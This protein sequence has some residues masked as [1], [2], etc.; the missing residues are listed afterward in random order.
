MHALELVQKLS[1]R[2]AKIQKVAKAFNKKQQ[3]K[4]KKRC[5]KNVRHPIHYKVGD[6]VL[7]RIKCHLVGQSKA[8][9]SFWD[10]PHRI[11]YAPID[12]PNVIIRFFD[13]PN[14]KH[15]KVNVERLKKYVAPVLIN[16]Y[17]F[18]CILHIFLYSVIFFSLFFR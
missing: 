7:L 10:G 8:F 12:S 4:M 11:V 6:L 16:C 2:L 1:A 5:D 17:V 13:D 15:D 18:A 9:S 14:G 3:I